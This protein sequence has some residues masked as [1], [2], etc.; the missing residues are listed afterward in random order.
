MKF[1]F[2][3]GMSYTK[4]TPLAKKKLFHISLTLELVELII[5]NDIYKQRY[6]KEYGEFYKSRRNLYKSRIKHH[7]SESKT[8]FIEPAGNV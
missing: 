4:A 5:L 2:L 1:V 8:S 6:Y 3:T 7:K